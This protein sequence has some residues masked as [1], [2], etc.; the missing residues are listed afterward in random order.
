MFIRFTLFVSI[1]AFFSLSVAQARLSLPKEHV[2][3]YNVVISNVDAA[4]KAS[5]E[6]KKAEVTK[7]KADIKAYKDAGDNTSAKASAKTLRSKQRDLDKN[8]RAAIKSDVSLQGTIAAEKRTAK[9]AG[10]QAKGTKA[11]QTMNKILAV[12][13]STQSSTIESNKTSMASILLDIKTARQAGATK[14]DTKSLNDQL[15]ALHIQQK[16]TIKEIIDSNADLKATLKADAKKQA[17]K[18]AKGKRNNKSRNTKQ[19]RSKSS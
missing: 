12:A 3:V 11:K 17:R 10:K 18:A 6:A 9:A 8:L 14:A 1:F 4:T 7:L 15:K 16:A 13:S 19:P 5:L 2:S